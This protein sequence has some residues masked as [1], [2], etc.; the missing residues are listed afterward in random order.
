MRRARSSGLR[1]AAMGAFYTNSSF[2]FLIDPQGLMTFARGGIW[3]LCGHFLAGSVYDACALPDGGRAWT[4][5]FAIP[6]AVTVAVLGAFALLFRDQR[7]ADQE[8]T[9]PTCSSTDAPDE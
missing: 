6:A 2:L 4:V 3:A 1:S 5:L 8:T 7:D 9:R